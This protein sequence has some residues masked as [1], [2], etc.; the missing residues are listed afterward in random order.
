MTIICMALMDTDIACHA[1]A[2]SLMLAA[3]CHFRTGAAASLAAAFIYA[4]MA[5]QISQAEFENV[6]ID[7]GHYCFSDSWRG[8]AIRLLGELFDVAR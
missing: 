4:R 2:F 3:C 5:G 8:R 6:A 1:L 7:G